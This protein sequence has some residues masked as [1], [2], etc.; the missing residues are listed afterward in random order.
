MAH[1]F[2]SCLADRLSSTVFICLQTVCVNGL[3]RGWFDKSAPAKFD[4]WI[5]IIKVKYVVKITV[6]C[7]LPSSSQQSDDIIARLISLILIP[8]PRDCG[9]DCSKGESV[10]VHSILRTRSWSR[11]CHPYTI[12][13]IF[14]SF[15]DEAKSLLLCSWLEVVRYKWCRDRNC[16]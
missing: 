2:S 12:K 13:K 3:T 5:K 4:S 6:Y 15:L 16:R 11:Q 14:F 9:K 10:I 7:W 1:L 8:E